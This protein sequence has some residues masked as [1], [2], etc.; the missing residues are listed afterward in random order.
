MLRVQKLRWNRQ[1]DAII[2]QDAANTQNRFNP[3]QP[4]IRARD[5]RPRTPIIG[6]SKCQAIFTTGR[7]RLPNDNLPRRSISDIQR[8]LGRLRQPRYLARGLQAAM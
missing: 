4:S 3:G 2:P 5:R 7:L 1:A 8:S 6:S